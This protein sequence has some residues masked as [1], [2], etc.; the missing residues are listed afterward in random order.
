MN[1]IK[2]DWKLKL[3]DALF[4]LAEKQGLSIAR[5]QINLIVEKPPKPEMGDLAFPLFSLAKIFKKSP[6]LVA[7]DVRSYFEEN[8]KKS[9]L[10]IIISGPYI[11]IKIDLSDLTGKVIEDIL[12][13]GE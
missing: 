11:N 12:S 9:A 13:A 4:L 2:L 10:L 8:D 1:D 5:D 6:A 3:E 7:E